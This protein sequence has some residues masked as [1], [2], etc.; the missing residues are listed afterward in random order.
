[1]TKPNFKRIF[2]ALALFFATIASIIFI[3]ASLIVIRYEMENQFFSLF[4]EFDEEY[5]DDS[6]YGEDYYEQEYCSIMGME[7]HGELITY[8]I[9]VEDDEG[10]ASQDST[11]ADSITWAIRDAENNDGVLA[12]LLEIDSY[13]GSGVAGEEIANALKAAKKPTIVLIRD[14]AASAAYLAA[15]GADYIVASAISD[16]GSIGITASYLDYTKQN[17]EEGI[18]YIELNSAKFKNMGDPD[19]P[20]TAEERA[21]WQRDLDIMHNYFVQEVAKNRNLDIA[22]V[23]QLADGSTMLG[24]MAFDNG[25]IDKVGGLEEVFSYLIGHGVISA[26]EDICWY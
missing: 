2:T 18:T 10:E 17:L 12:I 8:D 15:S 25:L 9:M 5:A 11:S 20:V 23:Q 6:M 14:G 24:Q 3:S 7:L 1:M 19:K 13:G 4:S 21:L 22:K 26:P 16:V